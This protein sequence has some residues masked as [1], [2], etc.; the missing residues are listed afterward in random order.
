MI[1]IE[2]YENLVS[3]NF[4]DYLE[5]EVAAHYHIKYARDQEDRKTQKEFMKMMSSLKVKY[6]YENDNGEKY[7]IYIKPND[8]MDCHYYV[9]K[10][11]HYDGDIDYCVFR[12]V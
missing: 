10:V 5:V 12:L 6:E 11:S 9:S 7:Y 2:H 1:L 8:N 3:H 4:I